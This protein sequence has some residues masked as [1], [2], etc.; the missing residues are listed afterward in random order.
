MVKRYYTNVEDSEM[1]VGA[2]GPFVLYEDYAAL[3]AALTLLTNGFKYSTEVCQI[4]RNAL[5]RRTEVMKKWPIWIEGYQTT[6]QQAKA[7]YKGEF[8]GDTFAEACKN[9]A[10][11]LSE[12]PQCFNKQNLTYW[13]CGLFDNEADARKSFG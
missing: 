6:G 7:E 11:S 2:D 9:W 12:P 3:E 8:E 10:K 5:A 1:F 13:G 4:A